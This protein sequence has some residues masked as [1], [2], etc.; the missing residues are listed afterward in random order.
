MIAR[1]FVGHQS[2]KSYMQ[3][4]FTN[5]QGFA[6]YWTLRTGIARQSNS[7][8]S[9]GEHVFG[10][11]GGVR[12]MHKRLHCEGVSVHCGGG[13]ERIIGAPRIKG[14]FQSTDSLSIVM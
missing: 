7:Y 10:F 14:M 5:S 9:I 13:M 1:K 3:P 4:R 8:H 2:Q 12:F 11:G 6:L